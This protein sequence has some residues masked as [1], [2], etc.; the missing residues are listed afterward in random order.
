MP[1]QL[2]VRPDQDFRGYAGQAVSGHVRVGD[3]LTVWPSGVHSRI[4]RIVT[5]DGDLEEAFAPMSVT[6]VLED[7]VDVSRGDVLA[8]GPL[9]VASRH[10]SGRR[11]DGRAAAQ[12]EPDVSAQAQRPDGRGRSGP[13]ADAERDRQGA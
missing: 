5:F 1:V 6:I 11:L 3:P 7:E 8:G 4:K 13:R 9:Q 12:S 10:R 2:V